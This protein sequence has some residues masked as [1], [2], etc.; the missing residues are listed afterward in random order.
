MQ[1]SMRFG[2]SEKGRIGIATPVGQ[3]QTAESK[4]RSGWPARRAGM[5]GGGGGAG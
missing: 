3:M 2:G 1:L 4:F 5:L